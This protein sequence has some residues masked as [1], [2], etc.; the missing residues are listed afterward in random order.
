MSH[1]YDY[2]ERITYKS[3][4]IEQLCSFKIIILQKESMQNHM[5]VR[6]W[7]EGE[8]RRNSLN[9]PHIARR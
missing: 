8:V 2:Q 4:F 1:L 9:T 7:K 5:E 6:K 3:I